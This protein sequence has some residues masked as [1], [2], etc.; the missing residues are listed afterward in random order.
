MSRIEKLQ[1]M[2]NSLLGICSENGAGEAFEGD[3]LSPEDRKYQPLGIMILQMQDGVLEKRY[4]HRMEK[5]LSSDAK[6]FQYYI[7]FQSLNALLHEHFNKSRFEKMVES[8]KEMITGQ[9]VSQS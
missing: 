5:W 3:P 6:A 9:T 8:I 4:V 2:V 7:D 1:R